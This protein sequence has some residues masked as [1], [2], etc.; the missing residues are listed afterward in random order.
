MAAGLCP[1]AAPAVL[2][3]VRVVCSVVFT[4]VGMASAGLGDSGV[5]AALEHYGK[6]RELTA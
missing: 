2:V 1:F 6:R 4:E 5:G 3:F